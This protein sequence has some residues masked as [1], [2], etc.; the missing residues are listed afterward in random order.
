MGGAALFREAQAELAE[1]SSETQG[2]VQLRKEGAV[3][4]E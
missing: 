1:Q 2:R 4:S 3:A